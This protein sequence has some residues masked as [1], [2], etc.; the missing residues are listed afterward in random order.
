MSFGKTFSIKFSNS[1]VL[2]VM[3]KIKMKCFIQKLHVYVKQLRVKA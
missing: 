2:I 1:S 3:E